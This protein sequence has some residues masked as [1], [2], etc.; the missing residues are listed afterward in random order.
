MKRVSAISVTNM[1]KLFE[2]DLS[3][4]QILNS[5]WV[6]GLEIQNLNGF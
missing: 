4:D 5:V 2:W 1:A 6:L 3:G